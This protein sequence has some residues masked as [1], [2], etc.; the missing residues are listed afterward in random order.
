MNWKLN[1]VKNKANKGNLVIKGDKS[2]RF[3]MTTHHWFLKR[4]HRLQHRKRTDLQQ[5]LKHLYIQ[6]QGKLK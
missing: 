4:Y 2:A 6:T 3:L 1:S 5:C